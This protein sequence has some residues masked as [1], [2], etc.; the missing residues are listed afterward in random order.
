MHIHEHCII[1]F[2]DGETI[3]TVQHIR[4]IEK[5]KKKKK[6]NLKITIIFPELRSIKDKSQIVK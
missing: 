5:K 2:A 6:K 4:K 1:F 3:V